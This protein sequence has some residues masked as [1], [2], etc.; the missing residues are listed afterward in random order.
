MGNNLV[1]VV[2][3]IVQAVVELS[4][5]SEVRIEDIRGCAAKTHA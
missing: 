2:R 3:L 1:S 4:T 5:K